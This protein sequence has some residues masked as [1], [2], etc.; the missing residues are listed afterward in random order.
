MARLRNPNCISLIGAHIKPPKMCYVM[1]LLNCS[2]YDILYTSKDKLSTKLLLN[3]CV[4]I[5]SAFQYLH[6][7]SPKIIHRDLKTR[8]V[9]LTDDWHLKLCDFGL[10]NNPNALIGTPCYM[11][12]ELLNERPFNHKVDVY[13]YG[14]FVWEIF[15]RQ[16]PF[17]GIDPKRIKELLNEGSHPDSKKTHGCPVELN[18]LIQRVYIPLIMFYI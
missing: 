2:L 5:A 11:A 6:S 4:D 8:N 16:I 13:A 12:P 14:L 9:L 15:A 10:C 18:L 17:E 1:E 3:F 7:F